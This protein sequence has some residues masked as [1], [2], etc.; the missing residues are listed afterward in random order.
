MAYVQADVRGRHVGRE[1]G[2][3]NRE[4]GTHVAEVASTS[5]FEALST[6][7]A[8]RFALTIPDGVNE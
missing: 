6:T 7:R 1:R 3:V 2:R 4:K 5:F 8:G